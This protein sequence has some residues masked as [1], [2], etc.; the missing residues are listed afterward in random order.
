M[1]V[2]YFST[3]FFGSGVFGS[4]GRAG[5]ISVSRMVGGAGRGNGVDSSSSNIFDTIVSINAPL[6]LK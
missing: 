3:I 2:S 1:I 5:I 6:V 4:R